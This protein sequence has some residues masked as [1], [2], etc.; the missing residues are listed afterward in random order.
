MN[1]NVQSSAAAATKRAVYT[2][3]DLSQSELEDRTAVTGDNFVE[4]KYRSTRN[5]STAAMAKGLGIFS[6]ALG[7]A[8]VFM[9][10][11]L[12]EL[13]GVSRKERAILPVLGLREIAHG[14]GILSSAKPT[15]AVWTRVGGDVLDLAYLGSSFI[16]DDGNKKRLAGATAA[17]LGV[18]ALD[19]ICAQRLSSQNWRE[20]TNP[21]APTTLGQSSGRQAF[22]E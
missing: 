19:L 15:T 4:L 22:G 1:Q 5:Y 13:A 20:S 16:S 6:I 18:A 10:S 11:Q 14:I 8:E 9:P 17:V 7:L 21:L 2:E 3:V 12:G